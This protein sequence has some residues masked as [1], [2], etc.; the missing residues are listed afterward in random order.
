MMSY[1]KPHLARDIRDPLVLA[2]KAAVLNGCRRRRLY[3]RPHHKAAY[4]L[5][6]ATHPGKPFI[7]Q[8]SLPTIRIQ[9]K[10]R[11]RVGE[12]GISARSQHPLLVDHQGQEA[13]VIIEVAHV[14][15]IQCNLTRNV[16]CLGFNRTAC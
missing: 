15:S 10:R 6:L 16:A 14:D 2:L 7:V 13:L 12:S 3:N 11:L 5:D 4:R 1:S 9:I 8:T